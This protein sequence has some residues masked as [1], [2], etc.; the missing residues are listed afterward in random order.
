M[1][2]VGAAITI[3]LSVAQARILR[4]AIDLLHRLRLGQVDELRTVWTDRFIAKA[5]VNTWD[6]QNAIVKLCNIIKSIVYPELP[7]N[8]S[9]GVGSP[10][11]TVD[12][13]RMYEIYKVLAHALWLSNPGR[14][15]YTVD[16]DDPYLLR[17]SGDPK[18]PFTVSSEVS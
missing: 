18:I 1:P 16:G 2:N 15:P 3:T 14:V 17:Y 10:E 4:N 7:D 12:D 5:N 9:Y 6:D 13:Q 8:A 11:L